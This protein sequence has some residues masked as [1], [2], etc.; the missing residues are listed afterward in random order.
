MFSSVLV[1]I[2]GI[3]SAGLIL[4]AAAFYV[5]NEVR[6]ELERELDGLLRR[7]HHS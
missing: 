5:G 4:A 7:F 6:L 2:L 1:V 3:F